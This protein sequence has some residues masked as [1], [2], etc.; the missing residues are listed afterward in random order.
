MGRP[1]YNKAVTDKQW[2]EIEANYKRLY[3]DY[4]MRRD[5][6]IMRLDCTIESFEVIVLYK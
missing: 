4:K 3:E 6:L 1:I 5:M 2:K